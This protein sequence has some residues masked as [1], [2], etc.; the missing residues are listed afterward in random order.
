MPDLDGCS[1]SSANSYL[2]SV[3]GTT[4]TVANLQGG[5]HIYVYTPV[6]ALVSHTVAEQEQHQMSLPQ[7]VYV[8]KVNGM[9]KK[10]KCY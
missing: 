10:V 1:S 5:E 2:I 9:A 8:V 6:G 7:G 4:V 3:R